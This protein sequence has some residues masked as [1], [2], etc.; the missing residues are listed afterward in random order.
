MKFEKRYKKSQFYIDT[1]IQYINLTDN[2]G[3]TPL[4]YAVAEGQFELAK[5]LLALKS[6]LHIRDYR[7]RTPIDIC[8]MKILS[9]EN[10]KHESAYKD[11][12]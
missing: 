8:N 11:L 4:H 1:L 9:V 6:T 2:H 10:A 7:L 3:M 5:C 12:L